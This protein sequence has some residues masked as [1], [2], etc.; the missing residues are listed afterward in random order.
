MPK[1]GRCRH[2][3]FR[4]DLHFRYDLHWRVHRKISLLLLAV[5]AATGSASAQAAPEL[6]TIAPGVRYRHLTPTTAA[7]EPLS[8]HVLAV[9]RLEP[10]VSVRAVSACGNDR[11]CEMRRKLPTAMAAD[12][13]AAGD[14][15]LAVINGDYDTGGLGVSVGVS[16][17]GDR[18]W[19]AP[20]NPEPAL[21]LLNSGEPM[22]GDPAVS[23]AF[24]AGALRWQVARLNQPL[25][26]SLEP[27]LYTRE[28]RAVV[29]TGEKL[30]AIVI[31]QL[32]P[33][34]PL[35]VQGE[36]TGTVVARLDSD[37]Q[38]SIPEQALVVVENAEF[39][40]TLARIFPQLRVGDAVRLSVRTTM[41]NGG[42]V[43]DAI[44]GFPI[45][46]RDGRREIVGAP[47]KSLAARNPRTAV[48][49]NEQDLIF[50]AVDGRQPAISVG[51][52]LAEL[53]DLMVSLGCQVAMN[54]DGG[55]STVMAVALPPKTAPDAALRR[56]PAALQ[57]VNSPSDGKE[58]G[59]G[60][61]WIV[62]RRP[63]Q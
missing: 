2:P 46:V 3:R 27:V 43:V 39:G 47:S 38:V 60:N 28:Y 51:M 12:A 44:G 21:A 34:L 4:D 42:R 54:T 37:D 52:T 36:I 11:Q 22:I 49:Y 48:C 29:R 53:A 25:G 61:A 1:P 19:T 56:S 40:S 10:S 6:V 30:R 41:A 26:T 7:G 24:A 63:A 15:V 58:R 18:L 33:P 50:V 35:R 45:L 9:S 59:R 14:D 5:A 20:D 55:G 8:I 17:T 32:A 13:M 62:V 57:I 16:V 23:F 31:G